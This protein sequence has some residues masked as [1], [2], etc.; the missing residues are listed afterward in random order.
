MRPS[1]AHRCATRHARC[2]PF[3]TGE[4]NAL[5]E[6]ADFHRQGS[7]PSDSIPARSIAAVFPPSGTPPPWVCTVWAVTKML[8]S[9]WGMYPMPVTVE[10]STLYREMAQ[11]L[12]FVPRS[13]ERRVGKE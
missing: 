5:V 2:R 10:L 12:G 4:A 6:S 7:A 9:G 13:E 1:A 8:S 11:I 3:Y